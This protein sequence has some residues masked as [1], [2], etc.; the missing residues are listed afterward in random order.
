MGH[1]I[2]K[3]GIET[4]PKKITVI[5]NWPRPKNVTDVRSFFGFT[6]HYQRFIYKYAQIARPLS[7]ITAG[8]NTNKKK[9][10]EWYKE[11]EDAFNK[12][13]DLCSKNPI[14]AYADYAKVFKLH[15]DASE[16]GLGAVLYQK[17]DDG[18]YQVIAYASRMLSKSERNYDT[19]KLEFLAIKWAITC[20]FH[21]YLYGGEFD[22]LADNNPSHTSSLQ[23]S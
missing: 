11:C 4:D 7:L 21:K 5:V 22:V 6:D 18:T 17:Q 12:K 15:I 20:C 19:H 16:L 1:L 3:R 2:S 9:T 8:G 23:P 14:L 13:K 10:I